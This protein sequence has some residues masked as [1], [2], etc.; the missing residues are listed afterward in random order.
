MPLL[1]KGGAPDERAIRILPSLGETPTREAEASYEQA[2]AAKRMQTAWQVEDAAAGVPSAHQGR[3]GTRNPWSP[4]LNSVLANCANRACKS[5]WLHLFRS[6]SG[7]VFEGGWTCSPAC[8]LAQ[9]TTAVRREGSA[10]HVA[11]GRHPHRI[12][13]G[14]G[15]LERGW[16]TPPQL[17][18]ALEAQREAGEGRLGSWLVQQTGIS[19]QQVARA[20][21]LQWGCPVLSA[22]QHDPEA[23]ATAMPR[24]FLEA[25]GG[26][27]LRLA[28]G[29]ILYLG[30]DERPDP[31]VALALERM[32]GLRVEGGV[33][34]DSLY[35]GIRERMLQAGFA[36]CTLMEAAAESAMIRILV[37]ALERARPV[38]SRLVRLYDCLWLRMWRREQ[39]S[40]L[41]N[42]QEVEDVVC[43]LASS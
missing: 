17:R 28:A 16:I 24:L 37:E 15:M 29:Q 18:S 10:E 32:L 26:L 19:E 9:V 42:R 14:L 43:S 11:A 22:D 20:L 8:T 34:R 7:P 33:V 4:S 5:G 3:T 41:P 25:F 30:F 31:V 27:P 2:A 36:P 40:A 6:R 21:G 38:Q 35:Q 23:M 12:P 1:G 13:L 39:A